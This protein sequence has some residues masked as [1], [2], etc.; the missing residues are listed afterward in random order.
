MKS[1]PLPEEL[2][3]DYWRKLARSIENGGAQPRFKMRALNGNLPSR[4]R[5][6][7]RQRSNPLRNGKHRPGS[8]RATGGS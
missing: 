1:F 2:V 8:R 7:M 5:L 6:G 3:A 4:S